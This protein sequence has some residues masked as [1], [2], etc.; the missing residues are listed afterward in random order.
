MNIFILDID[1]DK[2]AMYHNDRHV[3]K[4]INDI[5]IIQAQSRWDQFLDMFEEVTGEDNENIK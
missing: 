1:P 3:V 2:S 5:N 4:M